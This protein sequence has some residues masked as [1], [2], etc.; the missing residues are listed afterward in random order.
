MRWLEGITDSTDIN[1]SEFWEIEEDRGAWRAAVSGVA[2][3]TQLSD[4]K[5]T[6]CV[7]LLK[8]NKKRV[9]CLPL[10][11]ELHPK[12]ISWAASRGSL[13]MTWMDRDARFHVR[14]PSFQQDPHRA[15]TAQ[16]GGHARLPRGCLPRCGGDFLDIRD[17]L[18]PGHHGQASRRD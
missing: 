5:I 14:E 13:A 7:L 10:T 4:R 1:L 11:T 12:S 8:L 6:T 9:C 3:S 17:Q 16:G 18:C 2:E 15:E